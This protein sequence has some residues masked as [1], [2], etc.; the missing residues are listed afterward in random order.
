MDRGGGP[1]TASSRTG[2]PQFLHLCRV[3]G[4]HRERRRPA[5]PLPFQS[6]LRMTGAPIAASQASSAPVMHAERPHR[7]LSLCRH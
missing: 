3:A 7:S 5:G 1:A 2:R 4:T 6:G